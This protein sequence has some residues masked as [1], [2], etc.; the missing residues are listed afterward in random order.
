MPGMVD[1]SS[2]DLRGACARSASCASPASNRFAVDAALVRALL[3]EQFPVWAD[4]PLRVPAHAGNDHRVFRL[5][6]D[7]CVRLPSA[8]EYVP[9]VRK[10]QRWLPRLADAV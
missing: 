7:L 8:P 1:R 3:A 2:G 10:E 4:L 6:E 9:Q 5:G